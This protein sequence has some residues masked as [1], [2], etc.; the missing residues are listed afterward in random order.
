MEKQALK[1]PATAKSSAYKR[2]MIFLQNLNI[3]DMKKISVQKLSFLLGGWANPDGCKKVQE[4][5]AKMEKMQNPDW[6]K[7]ADDFDKYCLGI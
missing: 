1:R 5:A 6:D 7:W 4:K 3:S 2:C